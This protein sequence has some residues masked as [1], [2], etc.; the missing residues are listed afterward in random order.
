MPADEL[1]EETPTREKILA[2]G[3][4]AFSSKSYHG[5]GLTEILNSAGVPKGSFYHYFRSKEALGVAVVER[6]VEGVTR[7]LATA[8]EDESL[9]PVDRIK[10]YYAQFRDQCHASGCR[11]TCPIAKL[12]LE[13]THLSEPMRLAISAGYQEWSRRHEVVIREAQA[14]GTAS[15]DASPVHLANA[16]VNGFEG[17]ALR[18]Q[19]E[20]DIG[21]LDDFIEFTIECVL[22]GR[23]S[24]S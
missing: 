17:A 23:S 21:P 4:A 10:R 19:L 9:A 15:R 8:F 13:V 5:C 20:R 22:G 11:C 7:L 3:A 6:E 24:A 12:A 18:M 14:E 1:P 16:I 2:A